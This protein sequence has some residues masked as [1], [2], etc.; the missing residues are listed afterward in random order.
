VHIF[1]SECCHLLNKN[2]FELIARRENIG[3]SG[4]VRGDSKTAQE[5]LRIMYLFRECRDIKEIPGDYYSLYSK[6]VDLSQRITD[7]RK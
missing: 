2:Y 3:E 6:I 7:T 5:I 1:Y 4:K